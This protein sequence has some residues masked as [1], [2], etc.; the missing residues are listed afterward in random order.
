[1]R[2]DRY[3]SALDLAAGT[4]NF[5]LAY[6]VRAVTPGEFTYPALAVEDGGAGPET[7]GRT[8]DRPAH[9][10]RSDANPPQACRP[11]T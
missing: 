4:Q 6:V 10:R 7:A 5:T 11:Q 8:R 1:M 3:V 2:D 9:H